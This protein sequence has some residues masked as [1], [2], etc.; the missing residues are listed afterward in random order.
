[1]ASNVLIAFYSM[2]GNTRRIAEE[3]RAA[4]G[5]DIEE[6]G[7]AHPRRGAVGLLRAMFDATLRRKPRILAIGHDPANYDL[8]LLG[9]PV[10]AG[11]MAAPVR[12]Y[13]QQYG[14]RA[15][16]IAFFCTEGGR[17]AETA[18]TD[19]ERLCRR[20]PE[21][22]LTVD[23]SHLQPDAH[24]ADLGRFTAMAKHP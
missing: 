21:S 19:L 15:R 17:G 6:I 22:T 20:R 7:E 1:M 24:R 23:A 12:T 2:G 3:I 5:A 4:T 13:A 18:F 16:R 9:G 11:R 14:S 10:W 8:L